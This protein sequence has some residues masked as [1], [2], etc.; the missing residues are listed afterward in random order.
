MV[1]DFGSGSVGK[2]GEEGDGSWGRWQ[3]WWGGRRGSVVG[4][5]YLLMWWKTIKRITR[6]ERNRG[7]AEEGQDGG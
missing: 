6:K 5:G 1:E 4:D 2:R 7:G 3:R